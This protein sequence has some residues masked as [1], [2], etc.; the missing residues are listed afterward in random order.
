MIRED[1]SHEEHKVDVE[2]MIVKQKYDNCFRVSDL[3][4]DYP[5]VHA[6]SASVQNQFQNTA[7]AEVCESS[8]KGKVD[9]NKFD[10]LWEENCGKMPYD[11][12]TKTINLGNMQATA[13]KYNKDVCLPPNESP[14]IES[15]HESCRVELMRVFEQVA[16]DPKFK[17]SGAESI[18]T[19]SWL[20]GLKSL[21]KRIKDGSLIVCDT[22]TQEPSFCHLNTQTIS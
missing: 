6:A 14:A 16:N 15:T 18:L 2:K 3:E 1:L 21:K 22:Y 13:Y 4:D 9:S 5:A 7:A 10:V 20:R 19:A 17:D 12:R 11:Y 8:S